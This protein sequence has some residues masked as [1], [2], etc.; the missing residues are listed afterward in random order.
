MVIASPRTIT[1]S[2]TVT[3]GSSVEIMEALAGSILL[4]PAKNVTMARAVETRA[5]ANTATHPVDVAG[6]FTPFTATMA[7]KTT[8]AAIITV[9]DY[10]GD[11]KST[12]STKSNRKI[13][14]LSSDGLN[15]KQRTV[16]IM[17]IAGAV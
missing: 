9:V 2:A 5:M 16:R 3:T 13:R 7:L 17:N 1:A 14:Q 11:A 6:N 4:R 10:F 12:V 8:P 15:D